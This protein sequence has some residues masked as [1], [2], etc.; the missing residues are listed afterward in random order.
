MGKLRLAIFDFDGTLADSLPFFLSVF[1]RLAV[2]HRFSTIDVNNACAFRG[3]SAAQMMRHVG[4]PSWKL[5]I[6]ARSFMAMMNENS[7]AIS[8][9]D[10]ITE[11][12]R[13]LDA[14]GVTLAIVTS[15]SH[16]NVAA[17]LGAENMARIRHI[18]AGASIFGK[19][20]RIARVLGKSGFSCADA[21]YIGDQVADRDAARKAKV[22]FGAVAWGY[23]SIESL[24][25]HRPDYI[26]HSVSDIRRLA[27]A[28]H[29]P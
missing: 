16:A 21:I 12:L 2:Q 3:Y 8:V 26:F 23:A 7:H 27:T 11:M 28:S 15:N 18:E 20:A 17:I 6:V 29:Q 22:G 25:Q 5:P 4:M 13:H 9:F 14:S 24:A 1:N 19:A 10:G